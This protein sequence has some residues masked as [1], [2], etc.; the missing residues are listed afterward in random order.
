M[1]NILGLALKVTGDASGLAKSLTPVDRALD[2]LAQ[3]AEK[4]TAVFQPFAEKTAAAGR[5]QEEFAAKF[6]TLAQ[7]LRDGA[8]APDEYAA[9]F[10]RLT[11]EAKG[12][13]AA[14]EE[15]LR[16]TRELR[17][18]EEK[19][20]E[21]LARLQDLL[22]RGAIS[23]ETFVRASDRA[24]GVERERADAA[25]AAARI[26][27]ANLT[28]QERYDQQMQQLTGHLDAGR[29]SQEQFNRAAAKAKSDLD[30]MGTE[31]AK[32]DKNIERLNSNV[33]ILARIEIGRLVFDGIRALGQ[34]FTS[35]TTQITGLVGSVNSSLDTL[36]DFSARTGIGVEALQGYGLAAKLAG[37]DTE[38]FGVAVQRL[39]VNI[40]KA[41]PGDAL[42]KS[43]RQINLSVAELRALSPEQQ[44]SAIGQAI[45][46][47]PTAADRAAAAVEV[48]GKQGAALAPL[49]REG[50]DSIDELRARAERLGI[51]VNETQIENVAAMNDGFDLVSKT[52]EGIIGQVEGNLAPVV[53]AVTDEFLR[54]VEE[55]SGTAGTGGT[56][57]ANAITD[58]LLR[59]AE[60]FAGIFDE[61]VGSFTGFSVQLETAANVF[62]TV[63]G[64]L[65]ALSGTFKSIFNTFEII[66]NG[67]A[68]AL[69]KALEA[70]GSYVSS[71]LEAFGK[72][73]QVNANAQLQ[74]NLRELE[75][76]GQQIIDGTTQAVFGNQGQQQAAATRAALTYLQSLR[77]KVER[78]RA[79]EFQIATNIEKTRESFDA[80][81]NGI[82]DQGSAV[83]DAM[84]GF[85]A[86]VAAVE[87]PLRITQEEIAR[88][89][90][91][92]E[93]VNEAIRQERENRTQAAEAA[94]K[95]ADADAKRIEG[96]LKVNDSQVKLAEDIAAVE[97][98]QARVREQ[99]AAARD[100]YDKVAADA[101]TA[102][103]AQLDQ[104]QAKLQDAQVAAEQGFSDGFVKA[105]ESTNKSIRDL[106]DKAEVKS[107][108]GVPDAVGRAAA[109]AAD[110]LAASINTLQEKVSA[111]ILTKESYDQE[112]ARQREIFADRLAGAQ[113][114]EEFLAS[115]LD[116]RQRAELEAVEQVEERRRQ[117]AVNIQA[118][119]DRIAVEQE[120]QRKAREENRL[121]DAREAG[122]RIQQLEAARRGEQNIAA[123]RFPG[124]PQQAAGGQR[125]PSAVQLQ[126]QQI[127]QSQQNMLQSANNAIALTAQAN[128]EL[129][130]RVALSRP[131]Q[132]PVATADIRTAEGA[133]L[134][135]GLGAQAQ[136]PQLIEARLQTKQLQGIRTAITNAV[137]GYINTP[138]EIF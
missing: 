131:V 51:I 74:N 57:I 48:F 117:A 64:I 4:A 70:I 35:V 47:L 96:L 38:Q 92:Q 107:L 78:E 10:G 50:A 134:V 85:E 126:Q 28:P 124:Q 67:I 101:A 108:V 84:R 94:T 115:Q 76:A 100:A 118:I 89:N 43:L 53:T 21:E 18:E 37:V 26:I 128:A 86:A 59:G 119:E 72:D 79:P 95:Q 123:G 113:R 1:A 58:V 13:A 132:G 3:Q 114:V 82:V 102:R 80:F 106:L 20:A 83:T 122:Q 41:A 52:V 39:A 60:Y 90:A 5:A 29:L 138:A 111:G 25:A 65:E 30:G 87:D 14:F 42:D 93:R 61:F 109:I 98:E 116:N 24:T 62:Q 40:G 112:V 54:F 49:F 133:A 9:A 88:I 45:S 110:N 121:N 127:A 99:Q 91:A 36:N 2:R 27:A 16:V 125:G 135:L 77:E 137:A 32:T 63:S 46:Q 130:R 75:A 73:L 23:Q 66:G 104:L 56:G 15:G 103:L 31:A 7:Q 81:F 22:E 11:E 8:I 69:G 105:F 55:F 120:E 19:R 6:E 17:S 33:S 34:A 68:V 129:A 136:D 97:R 12:S 44:F 71:D